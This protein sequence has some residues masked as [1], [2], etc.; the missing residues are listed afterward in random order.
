MN[1][2]GGAF[3]AEIVLLG[4]DPSNLMQVMLSQG[5]IYEFSKSQF[6]RPIDQIVTI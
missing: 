4:Q 5:V 2:D 3:G 1:T 6:S